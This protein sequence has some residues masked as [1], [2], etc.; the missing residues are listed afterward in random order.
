[1]ERVIMRVTRI[2][3]AFIAL[4]AVAV[5]AR[6][7][8][9]DTFTAVDFYTTGFFSASAGATGGDGTL[10]YSST[11]TSASVTDNYV[12]GKT[13]DTLTI[14]YYFSGSYNSTNDTYS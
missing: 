10:S 5:G 11:T 8:L 13:S 3:A 4:A 9:A 2:L 14:T 12:N 1:M 7:A 6:S